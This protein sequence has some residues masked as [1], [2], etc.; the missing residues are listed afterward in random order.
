ML[1]CVGVYNKSKQKEQKYSLT[2]VSE[3]KYTANQQ[4]GTQQNP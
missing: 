2:Y 4:L 1:A 3:T